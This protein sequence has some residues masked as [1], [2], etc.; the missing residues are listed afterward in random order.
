MRKK[1]MGLGKSTTCIVLSLL[2]PS[3]TGESGYADQGFD[4]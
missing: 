4:G 1:M 2:K 3:S